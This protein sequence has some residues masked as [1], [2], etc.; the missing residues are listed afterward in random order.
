VYAN[1][2]CGGVRV[3]VTD[4]LAVRPTEVGLAIGATLREL[5]GERFDLQKFEKLINDPPALD[6]LK[7]NQDWREVNQRWEEESA[8]FLER[9]KPFLLY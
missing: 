9:R 6:A 3:L 1:E 5:Y 4:R 7:K 8:A 2:T